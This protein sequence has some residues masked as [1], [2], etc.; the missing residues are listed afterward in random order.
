MLCT[1]DTIVHINVPNANSIHRLLA[2]Q[3]GLIEDIHELSELQLRMQR[4]HV[5]DLESLRAIVEKCGF[6]VIE[7]GTYFP[8]FFSAGQMEKML[9]GG[10]I[11]ESIFEGLDKMI[12]YMPEFG[13]EIYVQTKYTGR[14]RR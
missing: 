8:K 3:M 14:K 5:Y 6:E 13:S 12:K 7:S 2:V 10:I 4:N 1:E 9:N 11:Q